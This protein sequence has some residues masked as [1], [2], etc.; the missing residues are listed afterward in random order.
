MKVLYIASEFGI[1]NG[2]N[3][4]MMMHYKAI[5]ES[6]GAD[7][8]FTV[9]LNS[10]G[11]QILTKKFRAYTKPES[12]KE[13]IKRIVQLN[14]RYMSKEI[15]EQIC[16]IIKTE[17]IEIVF[18]DDSILGVCI[19]TIKRRCSDVYVVAF[20]HDVKKNLYNQWLKERGISFLKEYIPGLYNEKLTARYADSNI[21]LNKRESAE[22][23]KAYH[24]KA[25]AELP[26]GIAEVPSYENTEVRTDITK[27]L[28][29][30]AKYYPNQYGIR[31]FCENVLPQISQKCELTIVGRGMEIMK[32]E[33]EKD[34]I[35][36]IGGVDNLIPY[37]Q[38]ADVVIAPIFDGAG[39]KVKSAEALAYG[40]RFYATKESLIGYIDNVPENCNDL[41]VECNTP[42]EFIDAFS[43]IKQGS[44]KWNPAVRKYF[45]EFFSE[46]AII[47][48]IS[49]ILSLG[50]NK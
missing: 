6:V 36:V 44:P 28:F 50:E 33:L 26:V 47:K 34:N 31:W 9:D 32:E 45:D 14:T 39:M 43:K 3:T 48:R 16:E 5:I 29:V 24:K 13:K 7:N 21:T 1:T 19:R 2:T 22:L 10:G 49:E 11:K 12:K 17:H 8:V 4:N 20:Y 38:E 35:H 46:K 40:K 42:E 15:A 41:I 18:V 27:I 23:M 37:Y 25:S 30:G